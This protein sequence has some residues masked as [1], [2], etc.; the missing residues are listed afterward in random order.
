MKRKI[1]VFS[2]GWSE[3]LLKEYMAGI[4]KGLLGE[5]ADVYLFLCYPTFS[6][7]EEYANG[8]L[9]IFKLPNL[10]DFDG[11]L[12]LANTVDFPKALE[13]LSDRCKA[14][15]IP[16][17]YTGNE[18]EGGHAVSADNYSGA[19]A[20]C[21]HLY[22]VHGFRD[23]FFI[24][25]SKENQDSNT[26]LRALKDTISENGGSF[27]DENIFYSNWS[28]QATIMFIE[29]WIRQG[30]KLPEVFVC[31]ND[32]N[33][34]LVCEELRNHGFRVPEDAA[35]TGFD[36]ILYAQV[37][38]PAISSVSQKFE[39]IGYESM[40]ILLDLLNGKE[41]E[42]N[43]I[44]SCEFAPGESCG[45]KW[46]RDLSDIR[47][48]IS[49]NKYMDDL[50]NSAF[51]RKLSIMDR[52]IMRSKFYDD[53]KVNYKQ[54]NDDFNNYEGDA[55]HV[56]LD[57]IF[58][59]K[60]YDANLKYRT[61]GYSEK[62]DVVFSM[63]EGV[64]KAIDEFE[65][66]IIVPYIANP[67]ANHL[68]VCLPLH[69][70]DGCLGYIV[71]ADDYDK[72]KRSEYLEKYAESLSA[73]FIKLQQTINAR[74][75]NEKLIE[76][77]ETDALTSVKNRMAYQVRESKINDKIARGQIDEFAVLLCDINNLKMVNDKWGHEN[78]DTYIVKSCKLICD[79]FKKS[80]VYRIGGD[81][82]TVVL[83]GD[84][85][86]N[87]EML[88]SSMNKEMDRRKTIDAPEWEK[89]SIAA[90][91]AYFTPEDTCV[92][93]VLKRADRTMYLRKREM[94]GEKA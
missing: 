50:D 27:A 79:T 31:A 5:S 62:M 75:L 43:H 39:E 78:G 4:R 11:A 25:G 26:R 76:L 1:A 88:L 28:P 44:I 56:I 47:R 18:I 19:K 29:D 38:E 90:G 85:Y 37:Y 45:C 48:I 57:P 20:L 73:T 77:S 10:S 42:K 13:E 21:E 60:L 64:F 68:F 72:L 69:E 66:R 55:Y 82:F 67:D 35:V 81:E 83:E 15:G 54:S 94:K 17:V 23:F 14:A 71:M 33:A 86:K 63:D 36:N 84:D 46:C 89:V 93:E 3:Q 8:E 22:K 12:V 61:E 58:K 41:C 32:D 9:N 40:G 7:S 34:I 91:L 6:E 59:D 51:Y 30:K 49:R 24:A 65:T 70:A 16:V 87:A 92:T 2:T 53:I 80:A 74:V 52:Y